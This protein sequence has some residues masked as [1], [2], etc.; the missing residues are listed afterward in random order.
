[1][2]THLHV[3]GAKLNTKSEEHHKSIPGDDKYTP[4]LPTASKVFEKHGIT[5]IN[6]AAASGP[7]V[8]KWGYDS[9]GQLV[10]Q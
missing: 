8:E 1:M 5:P 7:K 4:V 2:D 9:K 6:G 10:K 3:L